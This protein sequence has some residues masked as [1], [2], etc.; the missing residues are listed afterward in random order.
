[1]LSRRCIHS[2]TV[3]Q[4]WDMQSGTCTQTVS[5]AHD[6]VIMS[7]VEY[8]VRELSVLVLLDGSQTSTCAASVKLSAP[9]T[10]RG[11]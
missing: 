6:Q 3:L 9:T 2:L 7:L 8:Q 5:K 4:V 11:M 10:C 1:M